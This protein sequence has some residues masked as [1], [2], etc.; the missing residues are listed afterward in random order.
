MAKKS[1]RP[2]VKINTYEQASRI[3]NG[4]HESREYLQSLIGHFVPNGGLIVDCSDMKNLK[5]HGRT[6][7]G[8]AKKILESSELMKKIK[9][10]PT[11]E[12]EVERELFDER[13]CIQLE[14]R[15]LSSNYLLYLTRQYHKAKGNQ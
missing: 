11:I 12:D 7:Q 8:V 1:Q 10:L 4:Y 6:I 9:S 13:I 2:S 3:L 15:P 5:Y 14:G